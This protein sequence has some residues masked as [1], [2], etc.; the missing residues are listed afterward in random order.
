MTTK[1]AAASGYPRE[2]RTE[3]Q[4]LQISIE[5][6]AGSIRSGTDPD[7]NPW[8]VKMRYPYGYIRESVG[9]DGDHVDVMIGPHKDATHAYLISQMSP[10]LGALEEQKV[11][12]T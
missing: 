7:G 4:G 9:L 11:Y 8:S 6:K 10:G 2:D 3:F 12:L 1:G 5:N